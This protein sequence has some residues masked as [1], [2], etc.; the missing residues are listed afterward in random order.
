MSVLSQLLP[1]CLAQQLLNKHLPLSKGLQAD[2][3]EEDS[4]PLRTPE[5]PAQHSLDDAEI[6][7]HADD[8]ND[9]AGGGDAKLEVLL[10]GPRVV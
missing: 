6:A 7:G 1:Q 9:H 5:G 3:R 4:C 8:Q 10:P 2:K